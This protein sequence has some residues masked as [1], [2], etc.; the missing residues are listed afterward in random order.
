MQVKRYV[1][2]Q[3]FFQPFA[4]A[5]LAFLLLPLLPAILGQTA[6]P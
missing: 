6:E 4:W 3:E 5:G 2:Y 1:R